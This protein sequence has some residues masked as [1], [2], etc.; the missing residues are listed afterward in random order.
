[1][2]SLA[3]SGGLTVANQIYN[4]FKASGKP[5]NE[6]DI[7]VVDAAEYHFYQV[8]SCASLVS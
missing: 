7:A 8:G 5:L 3:G 4:R 6:K 1:M 2:G